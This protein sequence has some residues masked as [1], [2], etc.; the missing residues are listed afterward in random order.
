MARRE[1]A[2]QRRVADA[3]AAGD[4][5]QRCIQ[6]ALPEHFA[7][8]GHQ[9]PT[10]ALG[11]GAEHRLA[12]H[13]ARVAGNGE[14]STVVLACRSSRNR[15]SIPVSAP[16]RDRSDQ[17]ARAGHRRPAVAA[18]GAGGVGSATR[19]PGQVRVAVEA[20]SVNGIDAFAA[21]GYLWDAMPHTFPVI[22]GRD[23]AGTVAAVG[24]GVAELG[25]R[26]PRARRRDRRW[27][28]ASGPSPSRSPSTRRPLSR[29]PTT[30]PRPR[31]RP[32]GWP[33]RR[34]RP[35]S[36]RSIP[37][38]EDVVLVSGATGGVGGFAVQ[39]AAASGARVL[40]T[41]RPGDGADVRP[42]PGRR[43]GRGPHRRPG[44]RRAFGRPRRGGRRS[45]TWPG[46]RATLGALLRPGGRLASRPRCDRGTGRTRRHHRDRR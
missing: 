13:R 42:R 17:D 6:P 19:A 3:G 12:G 21:A 25:G 31:Q 37:P 7:G 14:D 9:R 38:G 20:A 23:F 27:S 24:D 33:A 46:T 16:P 11:V 41:A 2:V 28:L 45:S 40:A 34:L 29:C 30:S 15:G 8:R 4:L 36:R 39:L 10:V 44:R 35:S 43:H 26:R 22:L 18:R 1:P 32:W 5:V